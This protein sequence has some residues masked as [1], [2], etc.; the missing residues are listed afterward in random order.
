VNEKSNGYKDF[1]FDYILGT[2]VSQKEIYEAT[3]TDNLLE[4]VVDVLLLIN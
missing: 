4:A 1:K 3:Q 2:E